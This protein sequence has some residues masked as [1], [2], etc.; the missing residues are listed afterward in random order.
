MYNYGRVRTKKLLVKY[1]K[2]WTVRDVIKSQRK[3][4]I[5]QLIKEKHGAKAGQPGMIQQY[6]WGVRQ[7]M[8]GLSKEE[9][10]DA[11]KQ[12]EEW[13]EEQPPPAVQAL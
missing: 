3:N 10:G 6:Q 1:G 11:A 4:D 8:E 9:L 2:K 12:A 7:I 5:I 13:N